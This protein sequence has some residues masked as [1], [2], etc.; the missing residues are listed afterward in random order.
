MAKDIAN[1]QPDPIDLFIHSLFL[2]A[3]TMHAVPVNNSRSFSII[4]FFRLH[5]NIYISTAIYSTTD[6]YFTSNEVFSDF[7]FNRFHGKLCTWKCAMQWKR[8]TNT[9]TKWKNKISVKWNG[10]EK[11]QRNRF[12]FF[13]VGAAPS[14]FIYFECNIIALISVGLSKLLVYL[15]KKNCITQNRL[16]HTFRNDHSKN[17]VSRELWTHK[18]C[19][20]CDFERIEV[21]N[22]CE[23]FFIVAILLLLCCFFL[24]KNFIL[25][26]TDQTK[27]KI[28]EKDCDKKIEHVTKRNWLSKSEKQLLKW[29]TNSILSL[30]HTI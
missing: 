30:S 24:D 29:S 6:T 2:A 23:R 4:W 17:I 5:R 19:L 13:V 25:H 9:N 15:D 8:L 22:I 10:N 16:C 20:F 12:F 26:T 21:V 18:K 1:I 7:Q 27:N 11:S 3:I 14:S 28:E